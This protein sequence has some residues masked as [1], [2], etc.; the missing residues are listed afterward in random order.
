MF[1]K[2]SIWNNDSP[3]ITH[4]VSTFLGVIYWVFRIWDQG[5]LGPVCD[6]EDKK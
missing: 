1:Q 6:T 2:V 4:P 3:V 5:A